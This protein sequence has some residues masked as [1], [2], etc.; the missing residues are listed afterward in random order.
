MKNRFLS[1]L[2]LMLLGLFTSFSLVAWAG[3][4]PPTGADS[5]ECLFDWAE[6]TYPALFNPAGFPTANYGI[7]T[8]RYYPTTQAYVGV[9]SITNH[10]YYQGPNGNSQDEG[11]LSNWLSTA[12]CQASAAPTE[13]LF[14]WAE[15]NYPALFAPAGS[16]TVASGVYTYRH[17]LA[18]K[19]YLGVSSIDNHVYYQGADGQLQDEGPL[20]YWLP[21]ANCQGTPPPA[22][23]IIIS[24]PLDASYINATKVQITG[25]VSEAKK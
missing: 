5:I 4:N 22:P 10:V 20:S 19:D 24:N 17:Y 8:Y 16:P 2:I 21:V 6:T 25:T 7:Y 13:C 23:A 11:P 9:S 12:G 15:N 18:T 3:T 14:N 1:S